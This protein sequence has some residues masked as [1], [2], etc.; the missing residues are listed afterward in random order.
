M[1]VKRVKIAFFDIDG[2]LIDMKKKK[3]SEKTLET[4]EGLQ[5]ERDQDLHRHWK[6]PHAAAA[7]FRDLNL[8][9]S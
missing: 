8:T 1:P 7:F 2:T 5:K 9:R 6:I 4:P 3:I